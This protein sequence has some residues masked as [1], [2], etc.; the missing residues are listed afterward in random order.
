MSWLPEEA[1]LDAG[2]SWEGGEGR[3]SGAAVR[4][5]LNQEVG[6][7]GSGMRMVDDYRTKHRLPVGSPMSV[8]AEKKVSAERTDASG[9]PCTQLKRNQNVT[10][11]REGTTNRKGNFERTTAAAAV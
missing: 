6:R 1:G 9:E 2:W 3:C 11:W 8:P 4:W 7:Q 10:G 5:M